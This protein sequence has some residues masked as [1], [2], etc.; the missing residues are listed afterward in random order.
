[1]C[2]ILSSKKLKNIPKIR[3][4]STKNK[5]NK[6][7]LNYYRKNLVLNNIRQKLNEFIAGHP[8]LFGTLPLVEKKPQTELEKKILMN[9]KDLSEVN[10]GQTVLIRARLQSSYSLG[11][12]NFIII[13]ISHFLFR[14]F[15]VFR[16]I[17]TKYVLYSSTN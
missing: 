10:V 2:K 3:Q 11:T 13:I 7:G 14:Q 9:I 16:V 1:M 12:L 17:A 6:Y 4:R 8:N 15:V 5:S